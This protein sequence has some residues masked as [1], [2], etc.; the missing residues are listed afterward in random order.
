MA[1]P[2]LDGKDLAEWLSECAWIE[3]SADSQR[4]ARENAPS[5]LEK[6]REY[7]PKWNSKNDK[8]VLRV[9]DGR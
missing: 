8:P 6:K 5:V 9:S 1:A 7:L 4:W 3:N 2:E